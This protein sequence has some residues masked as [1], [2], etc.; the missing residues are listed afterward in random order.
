MASGAVTGAVGCAVVAAAL[1]FAGTAAHRAHV[2]GLDHDGNRLESVF[3]IAAGGGKDDDERGLMY[4]VQCQRRIGGVQERTDIQAGAGI[5]GNPVLIDPDD[6]LDGLQGIVGSICG[7]PR[8]S[9]ER[10]RRRNVFPGTEQ[11]HARRRDGGRPSVPS[12][13][14]VP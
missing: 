2:L 9:Q 1:G 13:T 3:E 11:L 14:S 10:F 4:A 6:C 5:A 7:R 12:K 8:R